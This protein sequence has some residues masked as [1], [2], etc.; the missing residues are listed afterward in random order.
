MRLN[1]S[2]TLS[3]Q[4]SVLIVPRVLGAISL[5]SSHEFTATVCEPLSIMSLYWE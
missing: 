2:D 4:S 5:F 1:L 3:Q